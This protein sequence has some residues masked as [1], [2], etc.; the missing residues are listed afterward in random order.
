MY[1][2]YPLNCTIPFVF[3]NMCEYFLEYSLDIEQI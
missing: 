1:L 2:L 3:F